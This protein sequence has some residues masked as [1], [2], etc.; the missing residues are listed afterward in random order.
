MCVQ[1]QETLKCQ[2][3]TETTLAYYDRS[4]PV[5]LQVGAPSKGLRAVLLPENKPIA[6]ASKALTPAESRYANIERQLLAVVYGCEKFYTYL[7]GRQFFVTIVLRQVTIVLWNKFTR[8]ILTW[9]FLDF[10]ECSYVYNHTIVRF[11]ISQ[12]KR[13]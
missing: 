3:G 13:W 2:I 11:N 1:E 4:K 12:V 5:V 7:Y 6:F 9:H 10:K 8:R